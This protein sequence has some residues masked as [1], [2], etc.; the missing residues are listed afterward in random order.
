MPIIFFVFVIKYRVFLSNLRN[1]TQTRCRVHSESH[2]SRDRRNYKTK[3]NATLPNHTDGRTSLSRRDIG[4]N[5]TGGRARPGGQLMLGAL[6]NTRRVS[7]HRLHQ[8]SIDYAIG[9]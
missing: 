4:N 5:L 7:R 6:V 2:T 3:Q 8:S 9:R 1:F